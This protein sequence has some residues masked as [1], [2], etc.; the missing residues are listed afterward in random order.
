M[1]LHGDLL[2]QEV[3]KTIINPPAT[4]TALE[5]IIPERRVD[6]VICTVLSDQSQWQFVLASTTAA[7]TDCHVPDDIEASAEYQDDPT[8]APG[9]WIRV[10]SQAANG[11]ARVHAA[12]ADATALAAIVAA[13]RANGMIVVKLDDYTVWAFESA[14]AASA[15]D[16]V[17]VPGAGSGRWVR[18]MQSRADVRYPADVA[19]IKA[20]AA[21]SRY[22]G[23]VVTKADDG[24]RWRFVAG[25]SLTTDGDQLLII[26]TAGSG[27]WV[28]NDKTADITAAV[29]KDTADAAVLYTVPTGFIL[30]VL[31]PFQHV[32][33]SWTGGSSSAIGLSSSNGGLSTKGDLLGGASGDVAAGL[34][35]TGAYAKGTVGTKVGKPGAVLV[36]GETIRFDRITDAFTAGAGV[37]HIPVAIL[38][39]P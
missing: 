22:D 35:S 31:V 21:A 3:R 14:S 11:T 33:T 23:M 39:S 5:A 10:G 26:P 24:T 27:V 37:V 4:L 38:L 29:T 16:W 2:A 32:T 18:R 7:G 6:G 12:V 9:R 36:A 20:I 25:S 8:T 19:A 30:E 1:D 13:D 15:S 34:L 17:V 28:R